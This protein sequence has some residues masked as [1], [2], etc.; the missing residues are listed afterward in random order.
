MIGISII[1]LHILLIMIADIEGNTEGLLW[2]CNTKA[3]DE[4]KDDYHPLFSFKR[5]IIILAFYSPISILVYYQAIPIISFVLFVI[6][7]PCFFPYFHIGK[8]YVTRNQFNPF[9]YEQGYKAEPSVNSHSLRARNNLSYK[10]RLN[11]LYLG[12]ITLLSGYILIY[13]L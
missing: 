5:A 3:N 4:L 6:S 9:I 13:V 8:M 2:H 1:I 7:L 11:L 12:L 10:Q